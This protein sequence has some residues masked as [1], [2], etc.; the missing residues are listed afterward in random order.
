MLIPMPV[1]KAIG[2]FDEQRFQ[3]HMADLDFSISARKAGFPLVVSSASVV[4]EYTDA[5]GVNITKPMSVQAFWAALSAIKSPVNRHVRY[6]FALKHS[7]LSYLYFGL[8][9]LRIIGG[10]LIRRIKVIAPVA[11]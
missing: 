7:P 10:Y 5:T 2:L 8:D 3:H 1:F 6:N 9:M 11:Y 4:Y